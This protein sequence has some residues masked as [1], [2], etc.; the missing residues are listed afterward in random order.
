MFET[1]TL[2]LKESIQAVYVAT[3][4]YV[5]SFRKS[6]VKGGLHRWMPLWCKGDF[7]AVKNAVKVL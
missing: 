7:L 2:Q 4:R 6:V 3:E 1:V 5:D